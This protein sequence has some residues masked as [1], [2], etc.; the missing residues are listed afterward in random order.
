MRIGIINRLL[1]ILT[2][3]LLNDLNGTNSL[4]NETLV[5]QS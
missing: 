3:K 1:I 4:K 2:F 5:N